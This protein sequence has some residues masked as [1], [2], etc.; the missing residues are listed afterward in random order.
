[1]TLAKFRLQARANWG[2]WVVSCFRCPSALDLLP[3]APVFFCRECGSSAE[4]EWPPDE[5]RYGIERLLLMRP[6]VTTQNW[7]PGE[8]LI[9]LM[10]E[11]AAHGIFTE[12]PDDRANLIVEPERIRM[13]NLPPTFRRELKAIA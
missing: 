2:R 12:L 6:D 11:N 5:L 13:D 7:Q 9:D 8:T 1:V 4:V 10:R 3:G